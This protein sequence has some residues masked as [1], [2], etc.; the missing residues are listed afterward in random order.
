M[1]KVLSMYTIYVAHIKPHYFLPTSTVPNPAN[2]LS[3][4]SLRD[5]FDYY[6]FV[7]IYFYY[8]KY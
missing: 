7:T 1:L 4:L 8:Y 6:Y 3:C 2:I 5:L